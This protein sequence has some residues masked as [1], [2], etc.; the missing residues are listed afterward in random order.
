M[1][2]IW[3]PIPVY[4]SGLQAAGNGGKE[5]IRICYGIVSGVREWHGVA[6]VMDHPVIAAMER[7]GWPDGRD[8]MPYDCPICGVAIAHTDMIYRHPDGE[9]VGCERCVFSVEAVDV[10]GEEI[11]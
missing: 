5:H 4:L 11:L 1:Q 2:N 10:F 8:P 7:T 3:K 6:A 9:I